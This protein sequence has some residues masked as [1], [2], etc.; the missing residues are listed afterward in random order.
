MRALVAL[1][2]AAPFA[3]ATPALAQDEPLVTLGAV[4]AACA[5]ASEGENS[6]LFSIVLDA[7][8]RFGSVETE[9]A[10]DGS[11][12]SAFFPIDTRRN[13]RALRGQVEAM[14]A[15]LESIGFV[16]NEAR[17]TELEAA[18][19]S[20]AVLRVGFFLGFDDSRRSVCLV[21]GVHGVTMVRM[22]VA[23][24][25]LVAPDGRVVAREDTDRFASWSDDRERDV[26]AGTGP[27]AEVGTGALVSG[28]RLPEAWQ[29]ALSA[30]DVAARLSS[31]HREGV[32]R[33]ASGVAM[34]RLRVSVEA[35]TGRVAAVSVELS[36]LGDEAEVTCLESSLDGVTLPAG[37]A[38]LPGRTDVSL[39]VRFAN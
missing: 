32:A 21:R 35:R 13:F 36:N 9:L 37:P 34:A 23:F 14:P 38:E 22:D 6:R 26:V 18:R 27:R 30:A 5:G 33:G 15:H 39:P 3:L 25:E 1:A 31:C 12:A 16:A 11:V 4:Q 2:L 7:G 17:A 20:G 24:V 19:Q 28:A 10:D 29:R 8:W